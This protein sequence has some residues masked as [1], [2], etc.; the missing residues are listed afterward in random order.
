MSSGPAGTPP[1]VS[2]IVTYRHRN[3]AAHCLGRLFMPEFGPVGMLSDIRCT[4]YGCK[5]GRDADVAATAFVRLIPPGLGVAPEQITW[6]AHYGTFS[7]WEWYESP[8]AFVRLYFD[9][10][11]VQYHKAMPSY[12]MNSLDIEFLL[13]GFELADPLVVVAALGHGH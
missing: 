2:A 5:L 4:P 3:G 13:D 6:I 10:G 8:E 11:G 12:V 1:A 9:W 7:S